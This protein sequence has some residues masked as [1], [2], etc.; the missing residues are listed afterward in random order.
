MKAVDFHIATGRSKGHAIEN[1]H[2]LLV[3]IVELGIGADQ[4][5]FQF[6]EAFM[7]SARI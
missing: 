5:A 3:Y 1:R 4:S 2:K 7:G 6:R